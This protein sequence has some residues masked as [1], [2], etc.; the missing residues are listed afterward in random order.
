MKAVNY[1]RIFILSSGLI[2][3]QSCNERNKIDDDDTPDTHEIGQKEIRSRQDLESF[4]VKG[5]LIADL[6]KSLGSP[7]SVMPYNG[8]GPGPAPDE[9]YLLWIYEDFPNDPIDTKLTII[10]RSKNGSYS[11]GDTI[12]DWFF[13]PAN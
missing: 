8:S 11:V 7:D 13:D 3:M 4:L 6:V 2:F 10:V 12:I 5:M 9:D 1:F